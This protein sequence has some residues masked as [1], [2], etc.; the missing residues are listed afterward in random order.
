MVK[1][2]K[3]QTKQDISFRVIF[4]LG[5]FWSKSI[6]KSRWDIRSRSSYSND[7]RITLHRLTREEEH[8]EEGG[9]WLLGMKCWKPRAG[10]LP[11]R[12]GD[13]TA[14]RC[15][16]GRALERDAGYMDTPTE[17]RCYTTVPY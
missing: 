10:D 2:A 14:S 8:D 1:E 5:Q 9:D 3:N 11:S 13:F 6:G 16:S 4:Q 15:I 17:L 12:S 7:G